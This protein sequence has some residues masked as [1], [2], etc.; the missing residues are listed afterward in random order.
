MGHI[1]LGDLLQLGKGLVTGAT[2]GMGPDFE[3]DPDYAGAAEVG[4]ELGQNLALEA[5]GAA[6]AKGV[7]VVAKYGRELLLAPMWSFMGAG[8]AGG[9]SLKALSAARKAAAEAAALEKSVARPIQS[10][11]E[12]GP[13]APDLSTAWARYQTYAA[14]PEETVFE[15]TRARARQTQMFL[16][17]SVSNGYFVEAKLG[18]RGPEGYAH[19]YRQASTYLQLNEFLGMKGVRY[20]V[21]HLADVRELNALFGAR[22]PQAMSSG[23]LRVLWVPW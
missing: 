21:A 17:D 22:F 7:Q 12:V 3:I 18:L 5:S 14:G 19:L 11:R 15:I 16:A 9:G 20:A 23:T 6:I 4:K 13:N 10:V 8:G 2:F 1:E